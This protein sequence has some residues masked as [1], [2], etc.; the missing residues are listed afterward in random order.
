MLDQDTAKALLTVAD[1][2][3][4]RVALVGDRHQL[5][6]VGR[7]GVL[8]LAATWVTPAV[9]VDLDVVHRFSN[10]EYA[11]MSQALRT[12]ATPYAVPDG[13]TGEMHG[14]RIGE[15]VGR[16]GAAVTR[17]V[18]IPATQNRPQPVPDCGHSLATGQDRLQSREVGTRW[19]PKSPQ[20]SPSA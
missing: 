6:A 4:V 12:G 11:A 19:S 2:M 16:T 10:H 20:P 7:G 15:G 17:F 14:E 18:S 8:D 9:H 1:Q 5:P 13:V 3:S